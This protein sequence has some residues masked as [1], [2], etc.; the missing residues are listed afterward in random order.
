MDIVAL[1]ARHK[2]V[3][4]QRWI[5]NLSDGSV[6]FEDNRPGQ[7]SAWHRLATYLKEKNLLITGLRLQAYGKTINALPYRD[8]QGQ[9]QIAGYWH[10]KR[11]TAILPVTYGSFTQHQDHGIGYILN[12][13]IHIV[14]LCQDGTV[15]SEVRPVTDKEMGCILNDEVSKPDNAGSAAQSGE[16]AGGADPSK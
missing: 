7:P 5:A 4:S 15:Q 8:K 11:H 2:S 10:A 14:W 3:P 1:S 12:N 13:N 16:H 6:V 9:P